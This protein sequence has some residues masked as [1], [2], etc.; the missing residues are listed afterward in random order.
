MVFMSVEEIAQCVTAVNEYRITWWGIIRVLSESLLNSMSAFLHPELVL[1]IISPSSYQRLVAWLSTCTEE[2][3]T[4][5][6]CMKW[7]C[8]NYNNL[9]R[10]LRET[11]EITGQTWTTN[12]VF[13]FDT[14]VFHPQWYASSICTLISDTW[15]MALLNLPTCYRLI[16]M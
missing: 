9:H 2:Q 15:N 7:V 12:I 13:Y 3:L 4:E 6:G 14:E 1:F 10:C 11:I 16:L 8:M 5:K